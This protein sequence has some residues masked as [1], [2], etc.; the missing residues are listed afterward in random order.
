MRTRVVAVLVLCLT[1]VCAADPAYA[2]FGAQS[3]SRPTGERY[4]V[5]IGGML[6]SPSPDIIIRSE[7]IEG[8]PG[9]NIDFVEDLGIERKWNTQLRVVLRPATKHKFRFEYTPIRY[10][11]EA[12]LIRDLVFNGIEFSV[13][14]PVATD[15]RWNAFRFGY[16]YDFIYRDWGFVGFLID[17]KYTDIETTLTNVL[18]SEFVRARAP[19]PAVGFIGRGYVAPNIS[20][21]GELSFFKVP[22]I[23]EDYKGSYFDLDIYG[24]VNFNDNVGVQGGWRSFDLS[25]TVER[26]L[27]DLNM[28]GIYFG[29]VVRF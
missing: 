12:T 17:V 27:G 24:T 22:D 23:D 3:S 2:Q 18:D 6:W 16:E 21:T 7:S 25:Y 15:L 11:A 4:N 28:R 29:G 26:D 9:D 1:V 20:I 19:I 14:L 10:E 13:A 8:I 5:E